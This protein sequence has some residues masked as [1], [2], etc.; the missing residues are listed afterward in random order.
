MRKLPFLIVALLTLCLIAGC[1]QSQ[2]DKKA[3]KD[4]QVAAAAKKKE[5][6]RIKK[7]GETGAL[8]KKLVQDF[9]DSLDN[10]NSRLD[11]GIKPD[12]YSSR[13]GD[14]SVAYNK[15]SWDET[16]NQY[17][18]KSVGIPLE[19]AYRDFAAAGNTWND[20][21]TD[22]NC[23]VEKDKL[24]SMQ[25]KWTHA[26]KLMEKSKTALEDFQLDE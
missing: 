10:L 9:A 25:K 3:A 11:V 16:P 22:Y 6:A 7:I 2:A 23:D 12:D 21:I 4:K 14:I 17:C 13:L 19:S 18:L 24:P 8:C 1:D 5:E 26:G 20:C 15:I